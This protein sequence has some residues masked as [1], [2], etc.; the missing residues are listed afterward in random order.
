MENYI[1]S[2]FLTFQSRKSADVEFKL[3]YYTAQSLPEEDY[4]RCYNLLKETSKE[5]YQLSTRG[6][7][8][9]H[10][11][12][13]MRER[14]MRYFILRRVKTRRFIQ[15]HAK[16]EADR[17]SRA[18]MQNMNQQPNADAPN[19]DSS[20]VSSQSSSHSHSNS[21][22]EAEDS[23]VPNEYA[24]LSYQLDDDW[25]EDSKYRVPVLY[26]YEIHLTPNLRAI[27]LGKHLMNLAEHIASATGMHKLELS[28]FTRNVAAERFYRSLGY[29]TDETSPQP[30]KVR[31]RTIK[32]DWLC[33]SR[34]VDAVQ[35]AGR[36]SK[37]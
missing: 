14:A 2:S 7:H 35:E 16:E 25:T 34:L 5:D 12:V 10:K 6:W 29:D 17:A 37:W 31:G 11:K 22:S 8:P 20:D 18:P 1:P 21:T 15:A 30:R 24:F 4:T 33:L 26:I 23:H 3:D 32:P 27:G 13:E 36:S 9:D 28:V 19:Q